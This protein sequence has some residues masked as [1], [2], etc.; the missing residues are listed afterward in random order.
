MPFEKWSTIDCIGKSALHF[1]KASV[2][3]S[4]D[5]AINQELQSSACWQFPEQKWI[6]EKKME[7]YSGIFTLD[8]NTSDT[9]LS[10]IHKT[11]VCI[12]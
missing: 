2:C 5:C 12:Y 4:Y 8:R 6:E 9:C 7:I 3:H 10:D 11:D 1:D